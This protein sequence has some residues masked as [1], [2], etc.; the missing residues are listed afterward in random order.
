MFEGT[1]GFES[2]TISM[3]G[4]YGNE[5]KQHILQRHFAV[6]DHRVKLLVGVRQVGY[7]SLL[8]I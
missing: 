2:F 5:E 6:Q 4:E 1:N 3:V 8:A 7:I